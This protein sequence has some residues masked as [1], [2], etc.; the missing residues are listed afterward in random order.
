MTSACAAVSAVENKNL[1]PGV[2][3]CDATESRAKLRLLVQSTKDNISVQHN[4][5]TDHRTVW[6]ACTAAPIAHPLS[7]SVVSAD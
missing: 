4:M 3:L 6:A 1:V 5:Q 7:V 2:C